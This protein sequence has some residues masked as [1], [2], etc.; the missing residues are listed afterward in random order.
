MTC[1][2]RCRCGKEHCAPRPDGV[3]ASA[4]SIGP[5]L[6][7]LCVYLVVHQHVPVGRC[8]QLLA[9][10]TGADVSCGFIIPAWSLRAKPS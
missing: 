5:R 1:T 10:V 7:A 3:P 8:R 4:L 2:F 6:R 9:D